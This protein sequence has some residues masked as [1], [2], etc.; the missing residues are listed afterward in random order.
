MALGSQINGRL[1]LQAHVGGTVVAPDLDGTFGIEGGRVRVEDTRVSAVQVTGRFQGREALVDRTSAHVLGGEV[2]VSG[3]VPLAQLERGA[4]GAPALRG[5]GPGPVAARRARAAAHGRF[6]V[7]PRVGVGRSRGD[8]AEPRGPARRGAVHARRVE[9]ERGDV[10]PRRPRPVAPRRRALRA[11]DPPP[12]RA[13]GDARGERRHDAR[14]DPRGLSHPRRPLRPASREPV[15][16]R[17]HARGPRTHRPPGEVGRLGRPA[18]GPLLGGRGAGDPGHAVFH[19]LPAE[20]RGAL[21]RRPRG[22]RRDRGRGRRP[23]RRVRRDELR[24][25]PLRPRRDVDRGGARPGE[26]PRGL[27]RPGHRGHPRGRRRRALPDLRPRRPD[28]VLLHRGARLAP[29]VPRPAGLPAR[30]PAGPG[31]D[32]GQPS[33]RDRRAAPGPAAHPQQPGRA[34]RHGNGD[35][36]RHARPAHGH[37]PGQPDRGRADHHPPRPHPGAGG[38]G[39]AQRLPGGRARRGLR[40][41]DAD[42]RGDHEPAGAGLDE[43]PGARHPLAQPA[44]PLADR[45]RLA[46][47][48]RAD[49]L[50]GGGRGGRDPGRGAGRRPRRRAA[51]SRRRRVADRGL[52]RRVDAA[53]R[54][55]PHPALPDR[56]ARRPGPRRVL[57]DP[58][59]RHRAALGRAVEPSRRPVHLPRDPG[60]RG[61]AGRRGDRPAALQRLP[62][63]RTLG[64]RGVG[65]AVEA[66]LPALRGRLAGARGGAAPRREA[67]DRAPLRPAAPGPGRR[68]R[69]GE[70]GRGRVPRRLGRRE[71][72]RGRGPQGPRRAR[73][74]RGGG[75][76]D[77]GL[78]GRRRPRREAPPE[79]SRSLAALRLAGSRGGRGR[80]HRAHRA[81]GRPPLRGERSATRSE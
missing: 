15:R 57:L 18:R 43:R 71:G 51:E 67:A 31:V 23:P 62:R 50:G 47:P 56:H 6:G 60:L 33:P 5:D 76:E 37:G 30:R 17:H 25:P 10:R 53:R 26:L 20:G 21:P 39:R 7:V 48:H 54:G 16:A 35:G 69:A 13:A 40:G 73:A 59:R 72:A 22:D 45:P 19:R 44:G 28:P 78:L 70:A 34:R 65:A 77:R 12:R 9:D 8:G 80:P 55:G 11:G 49:L 14:R 32:P 41:P 81:P 38:A 24:P 68:P 52:E 2:S 63:P 1:S 27:P 36:E 61:G 42:G 75:A 29:R 64:R 58:P 79:G 46:A 3:S 66:R 4:L 74:A